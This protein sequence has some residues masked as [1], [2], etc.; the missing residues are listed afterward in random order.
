MSSKNSGIF[1]ISI[2]YHFDHDNHRY[3]GIN[4]FHRDYDL[5]LLRK[6]YKNFYLY[7]ESKLPGKYRKRYHFRMY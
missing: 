1:N 3:K 5:N 7:I 4:Y 2:M 6:L